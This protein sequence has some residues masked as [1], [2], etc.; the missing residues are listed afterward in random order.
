MTFTGYP[1]IYRLTS[2]SSPPIIDTLSIKIADK[3]P[4][5]L[6]SPW[7]SSTGVLAAASRRKNS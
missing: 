6:A 3:T 4:S 5:Q 1:A 7:F 2:L